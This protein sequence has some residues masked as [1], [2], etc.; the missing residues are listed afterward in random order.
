VLNKLDHYGISNNRLHSIQTICSTIQKNVTAE[1]ATQ[2]NFKAKHD[3]A[4]SSNTILELLILNN[5][6]TQ[7][8][9]TTIE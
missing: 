1:F 4:T 6:I 5:A 3:S 8:F 7:I 9:F 2:Q